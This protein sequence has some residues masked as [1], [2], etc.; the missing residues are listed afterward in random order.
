M[1]HLFFLFLFLSTL[2]FTNQSVAADPPA[3]G[4]FCLQPEMEKAIGRYRQ[5]A[6]KG[7]WPQVPPG[8]SLRLGNQDAR[9]PLL[10]ARLIASGDLTAGGNGKVFDEEL[11]EAVL[12]FQVRHGLSADGVVGART[13]T[14]LNLPIAVRLAQLN[15]NLRRCQPL[16]QHLSPR[17]LLVNIADFTLNLYE[18]GKPAM[19]M[20]VIVGKTYRQTPVLN[21]RISSLVL[22]PSWEVPHSIATQD[23]LPKIKKDRGFPQR[24]GIRI[25]QGWSPESEIAV[26]DVNWAELSASRF[27]YR[28]RQEPGPANALG[29]IKFLFPNPH[30]VYLHD[31][32]A[33]ELFR[34]EIR[35][36]SSGCIRLARPLELAAYLLKGTALGETERLEQE[37]AKGKTKTV[38]IPEPIDIHI[39]YLTAW[40][41]R[42]GV[43]Q[44]RR[45]IYK[46]A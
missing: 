29:R 45:D 10:R 7:G 23:L 41:D 6:E 24:L 21:G 31:T 12:K 40:V 33:R 1:P 32:P 43:I 35:A 27:P 46:K 25:F 8:P 26:E 22:N 15:A 17:H 37:L 14:E 3:P 28:L 9:I 36:F 4:E 42:E 39:V 44:F 34:P 19:S 30:D 5:L 13:M 20:P 38:A 11:K 16:P 2:L 18:D